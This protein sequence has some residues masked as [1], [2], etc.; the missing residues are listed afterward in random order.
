MKKF[1]DIYR[2]GTRPGVIEWNKTSSIAED[3][4]QSI[5]LIVKGPAYPQA[6][7]TIAMYRKEEKLWLDILGKDLDRDL[8]W[9]PT[10]WSYIPKGLLDL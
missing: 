1:I 6:F 5:D 9:I 10:H 3:I 4:P 7:L 8:D 2:R